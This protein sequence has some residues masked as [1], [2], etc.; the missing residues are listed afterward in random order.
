MR[1]QTAFIALFLVIALGAAAQ[2]DPIAVLQSDASLADKAEACR[3]IAGSGDVNA[4]PVLE[5]LLVNE[6]TSHMA[7]YALEP[8]PGTE[9]D[10]ALRRALQAS[11][12]K[13]KAG[14]VTSLGVRRN[15]EAVPEMILLLVDPDGATAEAAAR[16]LGRIAAPEGVKALETAASQPGLAYAMAQAVGDGLFAAAE[17]RIAAGAPEEAARLY[18]AVYAAETL[19]IHIRAAGL[20]GAVLARK[21]VDAYPLLVHTIQGEN[22]VFY[23][24]SLRTAMELPKKEKTATELAAVLPSLTSDRKIQVMQVIGEL[25]E[26]KVGEALLQEA[27]ADTTPVRVAALGAAVRLG[28]VPVL[29]VVTSLV[30]SEDT[31]LAKAARDGLSFFPGEEGDAALLAMLENED[32]SVRRV[33]VE[34]ISQGALPSP[35][36]LLLQTAGEDTDASVRLAALK[37][38]REYAGMGQMP[39]LLEH[40][41]QPGSPEEMTAA[42]EGLKSLCDREKAISM[43][44]VPAVEAGRGVQRTGAQAPESIVDPLCGALASSEGETRLA[45]MRVLT[46]AGSQKAFDAVLPL[47]ASEDAALK[48]AATRAVCDWPATLALPTLMTWVKT[49]PADNLRV[50]A[51]RGAVRL[52]MLGQDAPEA[53]SRGY[54]ELLAQ[55]TSPEEKKLILSGLGTVGHD[56]ALNLVLDQL[57][58]ESVKAEAVLAAAAIVK[59]LGGAPQDAATLER[60]KTL[61]PDLGNGTVK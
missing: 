24:A 35:A 38:L 36:E 30:L 53:L 60:I 46:S 12:G 45:L 25:G 56:S 11:S 2:T 1:K 20:Q 51:F 16:A 21:P 8:M 50:V 22:A 32:A 41:L 44:A 3:L 54:A 43:G 17:N 14:I 37:G 40:L 27:Q 42:E 4:I 7:R 26:G 18:D 59:K 19:P 23:T 33:A 49:P 34:L 61:L 58:D 57:A 13:V 28:Y 6:E 52:L 48:E 9:A 10:A 47:V 31:E 15:V 5:P 29:P 39:G 55:A